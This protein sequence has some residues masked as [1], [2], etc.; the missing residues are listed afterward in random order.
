MHLVVDEA[1]SSTEMKF[2]LLVNF[3]DVGS[4]CLARDLFS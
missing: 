2:A 4:P 3:Y 1:E